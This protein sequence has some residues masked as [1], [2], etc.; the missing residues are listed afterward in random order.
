MPSTHP[1]RLYNTLTRQ[2][3]AFVPLD[4]AG[5]KVLFY[6]CGPTVYGA[7]HIGNARNFVVMDTL[8]RWLEHIGY[9]V[10]FVQN[11]TDVDDKIITRAAEEGISTDAVA[12]KYTKL[13]FEHSAALG[14][15]PAN[16]H[17]RATRFIGPMVELIGKLVDKGNAYPSADGSVWY[18]VDTFAGYGKLSR[19]VTDDMRTGERVNDEQQRL[20][21]SPLDFALWKASKPGEPAWPS[22]WG[23]GRPGWHIECSCM[24]MKCL[25]SQTID[26]HG[27]GTDLQF[28]H[29]ENEIAQSE[30]ATG[31]PFARFW[32]H[33]GFLN[34]DGEKM[35]KSLGNFKTI[36]QLLA[37]YDALTLRHF[38]LTAHY[39]AELDF[40][41]E[42]LDAA[43]KASSRYVE[44][45]RAAIE[46][47]K[48]EPAA[49]AWKNDATC[50][51][52]DA[53][54]AEAMNDDMN[55]PQALACVFELLPDLNSA[56]AVVE[57]SPSPEALAL[58][59]ARTAL[60]LRFRTVLGLDAAL[61]PKAEGLG[62]L[63]E[64]LIT[65]LIEVRAK[66]RADKQYAL[67]DMVRN[68]LAE[69]GIVLEDKPGST[70][71]KR[72]DA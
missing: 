28:P 72:K 50:V 37:H 9:D 45:T 4:P 36:D 55:T 70:T 54:F 34:I 25:G 52:L 33:N 22:P 1:L 11:I 59:T 32:V 44:A 20:K 7:F 19:K 31:V 68:R 39:R 29:H 2:K 8:R 38:L 40:T 6:N 23:A 14:V 46:V 12:E 47:L 48:G 67:G 27:G 51:A 21:R 49:D 41:K 61:E 57:K 60:M 16:E 35:S 26:I 17:P 62:D 65:L 58:L 56:R 71:W 30:A 3:E 53:R 15:R 24:A 64:Q 43:K 69:M 13:F 63:S 10:H 66:A 42:N 18:A 5:N